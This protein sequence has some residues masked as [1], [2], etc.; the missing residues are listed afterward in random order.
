MNDSDRYPE[1]FHTTEEQLDRLRVL[2]TRLPKEQRGF[3]I[4]RRERV[5]DPSKAQ[6]D[7]EF[8]DA[9]E[10]QM[11]D[12]RLSKFKNIYLDILVAVSW[13][14]QVFHAYGFPSRCFI[15]FSNSEPDGKIIDGS[16]ARLII[17]RIGQSRR[18]AD[19]ADE[20]NSVEPR[21]HT[22][23]EAIQMRR[24]P[25]AEEGSPLVLASR[26]LSLFQQIWQE[27]AELLDDERK[28]RAH[29]TLDPPM[30]RKF[31]FSTSEHLMV[32]AFNLGRVWGELGIRRSV[33][34]EVVAMR[35]L[36]STKRSTGKLAG[37]VH[38]KDKEERRTR[39][40]A[41]LVF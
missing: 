32:N 27:R 4:Y 23:Y 13:A 19:F 41:H 18:R 14:R 15:C 30:Q 39:W 9:T 1:K 33:E 11:L 38:T 24:V 6:T 29:G 35:D 10:F 22:I 28:N 8:D 2:G 26:I 20:R 25:W 17:Q 31:D 16:H 5:I 3:G 37:P 34:D 7:Q 12:E 36:R 40:F 21:I